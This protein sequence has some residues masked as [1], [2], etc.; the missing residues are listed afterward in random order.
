MAQG[1]SPFIA[2]DPAGGFEIAFHAGTANDLWYVD[3]AGASHDTGQEVGL[4]STPA[5]VPLPGGGFEIAYESLGSLELRTLV[6]G[7][8]PVDTNIDMVPSSPDIAVPAPARVTGP[9]DLVTV[10]NLPGRR[11]GQRREGDGLDSQGVPASSSSDAARPRV[12]PAVG[13][14]PTTGRPPLMPQHP[15]HGRDQAPAG[16]RAYGPRWPR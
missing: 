13:L 2:A 3:L 11:S 16:L 10:P 1:T 15:P 12:K 4:N 6:P 9:P 8:P 5:I 7:S 14:S